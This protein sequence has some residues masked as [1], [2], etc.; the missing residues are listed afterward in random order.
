MHPTK[1][2]GPNGMS[3]FFPKNISILLVRMLATQF[4]IF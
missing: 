1:S 4:L 3:F 2:V